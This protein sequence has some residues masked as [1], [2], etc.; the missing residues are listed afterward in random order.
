MVGLETV[1]TTRSIGMA[2]LLILALAGSALAAPRGYLYQRENILG[3][4]LDMTIIAASKTE[5]D[6]A[7]E[8]ALAEIERLRKILSTYDAASPLSR[9][10]TTTAAV[11]LPPEAVDLLKASD[12]WNRKTANAHSPQISGLAALY[13]AAEKSQALPTQAALADA[14]AIL[15]KPAFTLHDST[16]TRLTPYA[17]NV[18]SL[19][20]GYILGKAVDAARAAAPVSAVMLNIG[21][22]IR[23]WSAPA[24]AEPAAFRIA[25]ADPG[26]PAENAPPLTTLT[27]QS[28]AVA[29]SGAYARYYTIAGKRYSHILDPR[30]GKPANA[31]LSATVIAPDNITA[32][33]LATSLCVLGPVE[34][35]KLLRTVEGA[36][37]LIVT[38][39]GRQVRSANFKAY[40]LPR[41]AATQSAATAPADAWPA[42]H[43]VDLDLT[44]LPL[45]N[46]PR[47]KPYVCVWV[48]DSAGK[49]I[50]TLAV[51]GNETKY[52]RDMTSWWKIGR[53]DPALVRTV[54]RATRVAGKYTITWDGTDQK[55][56]AVP[57]GTYTL[58]VEV[59]YEEGPHATRT[60]AIACAKTAATARIPAT[61]AFAESPVT[62]GPAPKKE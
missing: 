7:S 41:P 57:T 61:A 11:E 31:V 5:A 6:K 1:M 8:A 45:K 54:T 29:T 15:A 33:A 49:H 21:G 38:A 48:T 16:A 46:K 30:T 36:E 2:A 28:A 40:E 10:N 14:V 25:V 39:D 4:S 37:A 59:A 35:M 22:D 55:G 62:Y 34:G 12:A 26:N 58:N 53:T 9:L 56:T 47:R 51:W 17:L 20:K 19:G 50:K 43:R 27:V 18:D 32:N 24:A 23:A 42:G 13:K 52:L 44:V 60:A 3:T